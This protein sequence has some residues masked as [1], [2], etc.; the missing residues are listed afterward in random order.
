M[1]RADAGRSGDEPTGPFPVCAG[2]FDLPSP[3]EACDAV[4]PLALPVRTPDC[5]Y[6]REI[7]L[8]GYPALHAVGQ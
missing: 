2:S 3:D 7:H 1:N 6:G 8:P 4:E 5:L